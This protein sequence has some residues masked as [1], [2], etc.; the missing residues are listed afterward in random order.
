[1]DSTILATTSA[2]P[3]LQIAPHARPTQELALSVIQ[4]LSM[5]LQ[6]TLASVRPLNSRTQ[7]LNA[8]C[9]IQSVPLAQV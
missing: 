6:R 3:V 5:E 1:M 4:P 7:H 9:V 8:R 2:R